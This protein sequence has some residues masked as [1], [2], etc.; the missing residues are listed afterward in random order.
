MTDMV[1]DRSSPD[2]S[3]TYISISVIPF[4]RVVDTKLHP[5]PIRHR[6]RPTNALL[7]EESGQIVH[8]FEMDGR[9]EI[10]V[11]NDKATVKH[12]LRFALRVQRDSDEESLA[13][14]KEEMG[15]FSEHLSHM[16]MEIARIE[17]AMHSVL[18]D[19]DYL[20]E[21]DAQFHKE[22][23]AMDSATIFWPIVQVCVLLM[24]GFTQARHIVEFFKQRR[25]I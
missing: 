8:Q 7:E 3:E 25:I 19:A 21:Q 9:G 14:E 2:Y 15:D 17:K 24:T 20:K 4:H 18:K 6:L 5:S 10:C 11:H 16:E 12:P 13:E 23:M 1:F 22:A